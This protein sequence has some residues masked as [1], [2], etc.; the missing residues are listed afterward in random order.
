MKRAAGIAMFVFAAGTAFA[1]PK[2]KA[3]PPKKDSAPAPAPAPDPTPAPAPAPAPESQNK[4]WAEG[5]PIDVQQKATAL[6][7]EGNEL[8]AQQAH[9]PAL[10]K[11]KQAIGMWEHPK[12]RYNMAVTEV[13]LDRVLD[14]ADDLEKALKW[15]DQ[16]FTKTDYQNALDYQAL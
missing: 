2:K 8:F 9:T 1:A 7:D 6:Y 4:P 15:G 10:E 5:V 16:P 3:P 13:R 14:A 12:I 11:Y